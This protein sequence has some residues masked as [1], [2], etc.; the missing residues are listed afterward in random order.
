MPDGGAEGVI[1]A[2]G[3]AFGGWSLYLKDGRPTYCYNLFGLAALQRRTATRRSRRARTR[4]AW[5]SPTTAAGSARAARSTLYVDGDAGRR[6]PRRGDRPDGLLGRRDLR[7]RLRHRARRSATTTRG[8]SS[9]FTGTVDWV[10]IDIGE[11]AEDPDHLITPEE[12]L[13]VAMARQ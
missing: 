9:L 2:Q 13:S 7:H 8:E 5:S 12:R 10:Q 3:G 1:V 6:G 4:C 11:A